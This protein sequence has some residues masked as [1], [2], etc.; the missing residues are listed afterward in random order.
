MHNSG[1]FPRI[2][3]IALYTLCS[4]IYCNRSHDVTKQRT[5]KM[6]V[7][8]RQVRTTHQTVDDEEGG[9]EGDTPHYQ[10]TLQLWKQQ[11]TVSI[12]ANNNKTTH[13]APS[14]ST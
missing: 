6:W 12:I 10:Q 14:S 5:I 4:N 7:Y 1:D 13:S 3:A 11:N 8:E 2:V 9:E